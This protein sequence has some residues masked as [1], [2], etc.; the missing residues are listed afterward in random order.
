MFLRS[1]SCSFNSFTVATTSGGSGRAAG[2]RSSRIAAAAISA[3]TATVA[4]ARVRKN[5]P[6][7]PH[8]EAGSSFGAVT[9]SLK[10]P[11]C[12]SW[13]RRAIHT[14]GGGSTSVG[15]SRAAETIVSRSE[16]HTSELQ[17]HSDLVCRLLL[18]KK[19]KNNN[20]KKKSIVDN[21]V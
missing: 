19:K 18:E 9:G 17:S 4:K 5:S 6:K 14:R 12:S 3:P 2:W 1:T 10:M 7:P 21:S 13:A 15:H 11:S 16:E 20:P 8:Q